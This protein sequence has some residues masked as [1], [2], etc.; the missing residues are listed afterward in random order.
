MTQ[1]YYSDSA[2]T[3][4]H[5]DAWQI[6]RDLPADY[7]DAV[8][9]DPPYSTGAATLAGK[10]APPADKYQ[11]TGTKKQYPEMVGD[12]KDQRSFLA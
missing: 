5:G 6:L 12:G 9:T 11:R 10:Q 8:I 7:V 2:V 1:H 4:Y 3:L